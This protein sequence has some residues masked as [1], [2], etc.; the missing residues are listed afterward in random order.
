MSGY[1][2]VMSTLSTDTL[3]DEQGKVL[4]VQA[5]GPALF[6]ESVLK[7]T[8]TPYKINYGDRIDV[9]I[10]LTPRGEFGRIQKAP[11]KQFTLNGSEWGIVSTVLDEWQVSDPL[12]DKLFVDLQGY[13]RDGK[14]FGKKQTSKTIDRLA[15]RIFCLKGTK[16][17]VSYLSKAALE[18]QKQ[19]LLLV[20]DGGQE[21]QLFYKG[22]STFLPVS[23][24]NDLNDTIGAGDTFLAYFVASMF[25]G[26]TP[27]IATRYAIEQTSIFL[28]SKPKE[29]VL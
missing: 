26:N 23:K 9:G 18:R 8:S 25:R 28:S 15:G 27:L 12:P 7:A 3:L 17:E 2:N 20:T 22:R 4:A 16:E 5:G 6:I 1:I 21:V 14:D 10:L 19:K 24:I 29:T 11:K 13:V